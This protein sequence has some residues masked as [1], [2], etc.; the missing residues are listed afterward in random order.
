MQ[1]DLPFLL[2]QNCSSRVHLQGSW[3]LRRRVDREFKP[4]LL[5]LCAVPLGDA[6][7]TGRVG[8]SEAVCDREAVLQGRFPSELCSSDDRFHSLPSCVLFVFSFKK[9]V[10]LGA[11]S[12]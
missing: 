8:G 1:F 12:S 6:S 5:S 9:L 10:S 4:K 7:C 11:V 3:R 2:L